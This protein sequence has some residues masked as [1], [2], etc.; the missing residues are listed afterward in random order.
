MKT[1]FWPDSMIALLWVKDNSMK[2][3]MFIKKKVDEIN[4]I[5]DPDY[6]NHYP[7]NKNVTD[8][9]SLAK[10]LANLKHQILW[11]FRPP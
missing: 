8:A 7:R 3:K 11:W 4:E 1:N 6:W 5:S 2:L 9:L 10:E